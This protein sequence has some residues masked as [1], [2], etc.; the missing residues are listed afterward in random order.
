MYVAIETQKE[1][2]FVEASS[3]SLHPIVPA[4]A[5]EPKNVKT[6]TLQVDCVDGESVNYDLEPENEV[7]VMNN[8]G[9]TINRFRI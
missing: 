2:F 6:K 4:Q 3:C 1:K 8:S 5:G 7:Y 9:K